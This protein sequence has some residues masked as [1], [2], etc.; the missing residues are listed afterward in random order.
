M[1]GWGGTGG[2]QGGIPRVLPPLCRDSSPL[3][4]APG[5]RD[6]ELGTGRGGARRCPP[7]ASPAPP[8][9]SRRQEPGPA[10]CWRRAGGESWKAER[11]TRGDRSVLRGGRE[12]DCKHPAGLQRL[13]SV[14]NFSSPARQGFISQAVSAICGRTQRPLPAPAGQEGDP[15]ASPTP[16]PAEGPALTENL[17]AMQGCCLGGSRGLFSPAPASL[18]CFNTEV[19]EGKWKQICVERGSC[20]VMPGFCFLAPWCF[21][22]SCIQRDEC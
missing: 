10:G 13:S 20:R 9:Q 5:F 2:I 12:E 11:S 19:R 7:P 3:S 6:V 4:L 1:L 21:L 8:G 15:S 18:G 16:Q 14:L 17:R 22:G